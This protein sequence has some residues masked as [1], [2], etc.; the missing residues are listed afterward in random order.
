MDE[1][2]KE[3]ISSKL[4]REESHYEGDQIGEVSA[5]YNI[6]F[7]HGITDDLGSKTDLL[8]KESDWQAKLYILLGL[9]PSVSA[10]SI[11]KGD[12]IGHNMWEGM[13]VILNGG[14]IIQASPTDLGTDADSLDERV[15]LRGSNQSPVSGQI[16]S[17]I[18]D[19][20]ADVYNEFIVKNPKVAGIYVVAYDEYPSFGRPDIISQKKRDSK[21]HKIATDLQ[22]PLYVIDY[23]QAYDSQFSRDS[24]GNYSISK[25]GNP[26]SPQELIRRNYI[27]PSDKQELARNKGLESLNT[28]TK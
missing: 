2:A 22:V 18:L 10:S 19:R 26:I 8:K 24:K 4:S 25:T 6:I 1:T 11:K 23:G 3:G 14:T 13:G 15:S 21:I 27:F 7:V 5:S 17:A 9:N 12:W 28:N 16:K 20:E